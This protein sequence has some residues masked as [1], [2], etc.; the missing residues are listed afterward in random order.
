MSMGGQAVTRGNFGKLLEPGLRKIVF[1]EFNRIPPQYK[2]V[3]NVNTSKKAIETDL[4]MGGFSLW[5]EKGSMEATTYEDPTGT[6]I[7]QYRHKTFSKGFLIEKEMVDDEQYNQIRKLAK[8]LGTVGR[9]TVE[10][11][12]ASVFN[13]AFTASPLNY[14]GEALI[15]EHKRLDGGTR[16]NFLGQYSLTEAALELVNKLASEM[17]DERGIK[18]QC[19]FDTLIVPRALEMTALRVLK[20]S[21]IPTAGL[22]ADKT[23]GFA[24]ND[25]NPIQGK[26]KLVVLDYLTDPTAWFVQDSSN[27]ELNFFWREKMNFKSE[28]DFDTDMA[29]YKGRM[30]YSYGWTSDIGIIGAKP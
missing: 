23:K 9:A 18:I 10:T 7:V 29:K 16:T 13:D 24:E 19:N 1:D 26:Y 3:F 2:K 11:H 6:D 5:G 17:V 4:R 15:G 25:I 21:Y 30:R 12:A 22:D 27:H 14:K 8:N 20:S 28:N